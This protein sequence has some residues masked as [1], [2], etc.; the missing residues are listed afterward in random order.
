MSNL[1]TSKYIITY[2]DSDAEGCPDF[3][4]T[5]RAYSEEHAEEKFYDDDND[6]NWKIISIKKLN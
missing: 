2:T 5:V 6:P 3:T 4:T 1:K